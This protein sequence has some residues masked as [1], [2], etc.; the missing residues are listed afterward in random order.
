[1]TDLRGE[2]HA[3]VTS[4]N[5]E[6]W[7][8]AMKVLGEDS[9]MACLVLGGSMLPFLSHK[10]LVWLRPVTAAELKF[11][12]I[13]VFHQDGG[14]VIHRFM[15][16]K[17]MDGREVL[18]TKGDAVDHGDPP[19]LPNQVVAKVVR[20]DKGWLTIPLDGMP[21]RLLNI[22]LAV[23]SS[24]PSVIGILRALCRLLVPLKMAVS[25]KWNN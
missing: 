24:Y 18:I 8:V 19:V 1:M 15:R 21:G 16:R 14:R 6:A 13:V 7:S 9:D 25:S 22:A 10:D 11:G 17:R 4:D 3:H 2:H 20:V 5:L 23:L 12:D